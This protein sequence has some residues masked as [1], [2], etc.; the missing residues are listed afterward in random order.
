MNIKNFAIFKNN[1][2][3]K[4][5]QPDYTISVKVDD[6]YITA[7][8]CWLKDGKTGKFFSCKLSNAY[9]DRKG[10]GIVVEDTVDEPPAF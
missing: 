4:E 9:K 5:T 6:K 10:F 8:G 7:G 3:E 1:K 2:K